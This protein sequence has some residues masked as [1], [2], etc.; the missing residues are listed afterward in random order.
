VTQL[1]VQRDV[2]DTQPIPVVTVRPRGRHAATK[3]RRGAS[4]WAYVAGRETAIVTLI[5]LGVAVLLSV[6]VRPAYV[7]DDAMEPTL[8]GG[9]RVLV[10]PWGS[11]DNGQ[12]V[13]VRGDAWGSD[14]EDVF[15]RVIALPG[16]RVACCDASGSLTLDG[17]PL[18]E[19]YV[20]GPTDQVSF[21][22]VVPE[23][24]AFVLVDRRAAARDS[25]AALRATDGT[26]ALNDIVGRAVVVAWPPRL[27]PSPGA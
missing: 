13:L 15:A 7:V 26:I 9:E 23:G 22:A 21:D 6:L 3:S 19:S 20:D 24:R 25:R 10:T 14:G 12:V 1:P 4:G 17:E 5:A 8:R 16:Q 11:P 2:T 27:L 18:D